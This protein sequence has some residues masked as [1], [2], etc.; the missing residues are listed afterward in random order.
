MTLTNAMAGVKSDFEYVPRSLGAVAEAALGASGDPRRLNRIFDHNLVPLLMVD[1]RRRCVEANRPARLAFRLSL[2][3]IR[4]HTV[5]DLS[6]PELLGEMERQWARLLDTGRVTG[7]YQLAGGEATRL[8][9]VYYALANV[10]PGLHLFAFVPAAWPED[11]LGVE[12]DGHDLAASLTPREIDVLI[13]A[14]DGLSGPELAKELFVSRA[15][16]N[17]H[18]RNIYVKLGVRSRAAAVAKAMRHGVI[19]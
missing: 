18:F 2:A 6:T 14:A 11:E 17:T 9:I 4:N 1:G 19:C 8:E 12:D 10:L 5:D 7:R 16:I 3:E 13:L 15:T